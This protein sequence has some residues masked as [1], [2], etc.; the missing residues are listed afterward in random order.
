VDC[1]RA[2]S[3]LTAKAVVE[4]QVDAEQ[5]RKI[6]CLVQADSLEQRHAWEEAEVK[7]DPN[8]VPSKNAM[9]IYDLGRRQQWGSGV[10]RRLGTLHC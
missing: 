1:Y 9:M 4:V 7:R 3:S 6:A 8:C 2:F 10:D 5:A